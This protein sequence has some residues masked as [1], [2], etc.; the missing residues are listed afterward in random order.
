VAA[1]IVK[2]PISQR[3]PIVLGKVSAGEFAACLDANGNFVGMILI[4]GKPL[5]SEMF[6]GGRMAQ[7]DSD[8]G[9]G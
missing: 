4:D 6:A 7:K 5:T 8:D 9:Q 3:R 2:I 1:D